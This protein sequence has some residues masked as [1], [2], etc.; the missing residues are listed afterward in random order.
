MIRKPLAATA[1]LAALAA[2]AAPAPALAQVRPTTPLGGESPTAGIHLPSPSLVGEGDASALEVNPAALGS[3]EG[4]SVLY[5]HAELRSDGRANGTGDALLAASP[6]PYLRSLVVGLGV[7]W[8]RPAD[9]IGYANHAKL[10]FGLALRGAKASLGLAYH[11]F[12]ADGDPDLDDLGTFDL[13]LTLRPFE[14]LGAGLVVRDLATPVYRGLPLQRVYDLE[15]TLRPLRT[16]RLELGLGLAI[17]ERREEVD[18]HLRLYGEPVPGFRLFAGAQLLRRDFY[19][20]GGAAT[21][22]RATVGFGFDLERV[23]IAVS[24]LAGRSFDPPAIGQSGGGLAPS[25]T[26]SAYQGIAATLRLHGARQP[27]MVPLGRKLLWVELSERLSQRTLVELA[28]LFR[29]V[30]QRADVRALLF[31]LDGIE[32]GWAQAQELRAWVKRLQRAGKKVYAFLKAGGARDYYIAAAADR[33]LLDPAGAVGLKGW[34]ARSMHLRGTFDLLGASPQFVKIAEYKSAPETYTRKAPSPEAR[35]MVKALFDDLYGQMLRDLAADRR[36]S[37][38]ELERLVDEGP[39][40][41]DR[42]LRS[43]L[44]DE[45]VESGTLKATV[46]KLADAQLVKARELERASDRWPVGPAVA[47]VVVE[48]DIVKGESAEIPLIGRRVV[49]DETIVKA[50]AAARASPTVKAVVIRVQSPGGSAWASDK[51]WNEARRLRE[52]KPLIVSMGDV[53]ASGGYYIACAGDYV[54]AS[55]GTVTGSI[56]IFTGKFD[57]SGLLA[58][59]GVTS[60]TI[61]ERGKR[62]QLESFERPYSEEERRFVLS[63]LQYYYRQFLSAVGKGRKL[64]ADRVHEVA[65]G[66]VWTGAQARGKGLVDEHGGLIDA[67]EEAKRRAGL[68]GRPARIVVLPEEKRSLLGRVLGLMGRAEGQSTSAL[69]QALPPAVLDALRAIPTVLLRARSGEPLAR[70]PFEL[71]LP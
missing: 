29:L 53:A 15:V 11:S 2:L 35:A 67:I 18:P 16:R 31:E 60:T 56:G 59:L 44:V 49:G 6:V 46:E 3:L 57:L 58:K 68:A 36:M 48:G 30:E 33:V 28:G 41:P 38:G 66:R 54:Y 9:A 1:T 25:P 65:R 71:A 14:W 24:A 52:V 51:I 4:W 62:A 5:H 42:A 7:Q 47:V 43:K 20:T 70:M 39:F 22:V 50:L 17:G 40:T 23:G 27:P 26:R 21:D 34:A 12:I 19:R 32:L 8:L 63:Q 45:L 37:S 69:Q 10:S 55:P 64:S 61:A 13:G